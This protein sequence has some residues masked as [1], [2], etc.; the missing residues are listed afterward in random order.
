MGGGVPCRPIRRSPGEDFG[1]TFVDAR[2]HFGALS[3]EAS[4]GRRRS[5]SA[6]SGNIDSER[7]GS[8][9]DLHR[10]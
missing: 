3:S 4:G 6:D 10:G 2:R 9:R 5:R 8:A 7:P 1:D